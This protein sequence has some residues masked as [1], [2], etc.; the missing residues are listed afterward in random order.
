MLQVG[1]VSLNAFLIAHGK[2]LAVF[3]VG[4]SISFVWSLN[5]QKVV[6]GG[7]KERIIYSAGAG[8][9]G[10]IGLYL[11]QNIVKWL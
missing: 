5:V 6:F 3:F 1:L 9:G 8:T 4:A 2:I 7:I 10:V 11:A